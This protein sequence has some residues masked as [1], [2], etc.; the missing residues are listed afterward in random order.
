MSSTGP[1]MN[2]AAIEVAVGA[3]LRYIDEDSGREGLWRTPERVAEMYT[4]LFSGVGLDPAAEIDA[5]FSDDV[6]HDPVLVAD[7]PFYSMCEHH[8][9]P[10]FGRASL[11]YVPDLHIAGISKIGRALDTT[12]RRL[13]V[14]ERL[15]AQLADA[16]MSR[17]QPL[18]VACRVEAEHLCMSMR[19]IQKP[20]H[21]VVTTAIRQAPGGGANGAAPTY[22]P[23]ELLSLLDNRG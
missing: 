11:V 23:N 12:A 14:Q 6:T 18:V 20:G 10:F 8:L 3:I 4:E 17:V 2:L 15:T 9:L 1:K 16:V 13:Q 21:R 5:I 7:L 19:G 22:S